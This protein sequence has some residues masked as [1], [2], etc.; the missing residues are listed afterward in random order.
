MNIKILENGDLEYDQYWSNGLGVGYLRSALPTNHPEYLYNY[1]KRNGI[2][3]PEFYGIEHGLF[4]KIKEKYQYYSL[5]EL[6]NVICDLSQE[7]KILER[8]T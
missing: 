1:L 7:I 8:Y 3:K 5:D 4:T 2:E 6:L